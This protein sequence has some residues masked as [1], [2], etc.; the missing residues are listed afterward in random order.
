MPIR[1]ERA[2]VARG[3]VLGLLAFFLLPA[4]HNGGGGGGG[5]SG[6]YPPFLRHKGFDLHVQ[7][8]ATALDGSG[9]VY[10]GGMFNTY[11]AISSTRIARLN[12]DAILDPSFGVGNGFNNL[13]TAIAP[14]ADGSGDIYVGGFFSIYNGTNVNGLVRLNPDGSVDTGFVVGTGFDGGVESIALAADG[15]GDLYV[16]GAFTSYNGTPSNRII[17]LNSDGTVDTAFAIGS[18]FDNVVR[19]I[20]PAADG[21]GD[22][23]VGGEFTLYKGVKADFIARLRADGTWR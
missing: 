1:Q 15:S 11:D 9:D 12:A 2:L 22:V 19:A 6:V 21:S 8:L 3:I 5:T 16:G 14:V 13:V 20:V 10:V 17:R 4:C 23:F 7:S 18:G